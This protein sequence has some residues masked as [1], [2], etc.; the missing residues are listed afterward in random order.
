LWLV[1]RW[2]RGEIYEFIVCTHH[3]FASSTIAVSGNPHS[4]HG[5]A[6]RWSSEKFNRILGDDRS[7]H[8]LNRGFIRSVEDNDPIAKHFGRHEM[9]AKRGVA[10][11]SLGAR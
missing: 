10:G 5:G 6:H 8:K 4:G 2:G 1:I 9:N 3:A 7:H 11:Y